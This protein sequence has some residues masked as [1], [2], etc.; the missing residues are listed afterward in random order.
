[1]LD[2]PLAWEI[3]VEN[4]DFELLVPL[5]PATAFAILLSSLSL[6]FLNIESLSNEALKILESAS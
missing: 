3:W 2:H 5:N 1:L 6:S 4:S